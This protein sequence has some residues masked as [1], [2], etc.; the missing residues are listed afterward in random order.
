[1]ASRNHKES[2]KLGGLKY[3]LKH[4]DF[5]HNWVKLEHFSNQPFN[6]P[7]NIFME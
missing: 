5:L 6:I 4:E 2:L 1:M 7:W 3:V